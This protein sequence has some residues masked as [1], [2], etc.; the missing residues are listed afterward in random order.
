MAG[1]MVEEAASMAYEGQRVALCDCLLQLQ[2]TLGG[3]TIR[4][5]VDSGATL[6]LLLDTH[7]DDTI[8]RSKVAPIAV[9]TAS[10]EMQYL[11]E[12]V[13]M[14]LEFQGYPYVFDFYLTAALPAD[15][16][17]GVQGMNQAGWV[18]N[19]PLKTIHHLT[20]ALPPLR[21]SSCRHSAVLAYAVVDTTIPARTWTRVLVA[22]HVPTDIDESTIVVLTPTTPPTLALHGAPTAFAGKEQPH[23]ALL[24][25][26][27]DTAVTVPAGRPVAYWEEGHVIG[28]HEAYVLTEASSPLARVEQE[29]DLGQVRAHWTPAE[30]GS[31]IKVLEKWHVTW[32]DP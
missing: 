31:L 17:I 12:K 2:T 19:V 9:M 11:N 24:C 28:H 13:T 1:A 30:V 25:N 32:T 8:T 10:R 29:F 20:H 26:T 15:A 4:V 3:K 16:L 21:C 14:V 5:I 18:V 27:A 23:F 6:N 22:R 7:V